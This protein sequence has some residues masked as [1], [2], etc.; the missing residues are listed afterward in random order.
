[1]YKYAGK[2]LLFKI[3]ED[4]RSDAI[5]ISIPLLF[6]YEINN[7]LKTAVKVFRVNPKEAKDIFKGFLNLNFTAFF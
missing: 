6:Y 5:K 4:F 7:I 1:M 3:R 2:L